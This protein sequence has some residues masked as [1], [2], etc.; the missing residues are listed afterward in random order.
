VKP[1][2][3]DLR[4]PDP[5]VSDGRIGKRPREHSGSTGSSRRWAGRSPRR[6]AAR[7]VEH[8]V[9]AFTQSAT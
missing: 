2:S 9:D 6:P 1:E 8:G 7:Y 4:G 3:P 5:M